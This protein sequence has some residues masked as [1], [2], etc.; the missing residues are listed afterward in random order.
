[1]YELDI[2]FRFIEARRDRHLQMLREESLAALRE[3]LLRDGRCWAMLAALALLTGL[4]GYSIAAAFVPTMILAL[5]AWVGVGAALSK[6][7][8]QRRLAAR[9]ERSRLLRGLRMR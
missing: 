5:A 4:A 8:L 6:P 3:T 1:M 9:S 2:D 7:R